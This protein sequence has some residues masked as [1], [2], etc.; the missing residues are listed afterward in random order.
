MWAEVREGMWRRP[1][2]SLER[3]RSPGCVVHFRAHLFGAVPF[4]EPSSLLERSSLPVL[5]QAHVV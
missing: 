2:P 5:A 4:T 1:G 3:V